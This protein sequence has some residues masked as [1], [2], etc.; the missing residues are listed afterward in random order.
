MARND[1]EDDPNDPGG[2]AEG[3]GDGD[4]QDVAPEDDLSE[5]PATEAPT[6]D[7]TEW[8]FNVD[9]VGPDGVTEDTSTPGPIE[10]DNVQLEHAVFVV[11]GVALAI[12]VLLTAVL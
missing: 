12:G 1:P 4:V 7:E 8:R 9:D 3:D 11:A 6:A 5:R 10:P 2:E